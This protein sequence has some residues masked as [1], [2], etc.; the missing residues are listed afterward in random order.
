MKI[1]SISYIELIAAF[2]INSF[3]ILRPVLTRYSYISKLIL[4]IEVGILMLIYLFNS[5]FRID[6]NNTIRMFI[7]TLFVSL[8]FA[9]DFIFRRNRLTW[10]Y[11][12][13]FLIYGFLSAV[14]FINVKDYE[15]LLKYW[16]VI[17]IVGGCLVLADPFNKYAISGSYMDF[18]TAMLPAFAAGVIA[19]DHFKLKIILPLLVVFLL[20]II[21]YANKGA[22][23]SALSII[24]FFVLYMTKDSKKIVNRI[25]IVLIF[26]TIIMLF[27]SSILTYLYK[28]SDYLGVAS[29]S[30]G[31]GISQDARLNSYYIRN[32]I[33]NFVG[34]ELKKNSIIGMGIGGFEVIYSNYAHNFFLDILITHGILIGSVIFLVIAAFIIK[35]FRCKYKEKFIF[36]LVILLLWILPM[37]FS[38]TYW[39]VIYFWLFLIISI[40]KIHGKENIGNNNEGIDTYI[41]HR[42]S[43]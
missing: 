33:W 6:K 8:W 32:D 40:Y 16:T 12:Y 22:T 19:Y 42:L 10:D 30:L 41:R 25:L 4:T 20:E 3:V 31:N 9:M 35:T 14:F 43:E 5:K 34:I 28:L 15:K 1:K 18:G 37:I 38:F 39:K 2:Y 36:S 24:L 11:Y 27:Y 13:Y 21:I 26:V 17:A 7:F 23:F 29:Y